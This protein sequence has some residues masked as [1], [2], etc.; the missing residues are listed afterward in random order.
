MSAPIRCETRDDLSMYAPKRARDAA[1][2][3]EAVLPNA[4]ALIE[5]G[6]RWLRPVAAFE[7][8]V[9]VRQ[10]R[11]RQ[12]IAPQRVPDPPLPASGNGAAGMFGRLFVAV[13]LA[14][15]AA[16]F[17][18]GAVP[19]PQVQSLAHGDPELAPA[20]LLSR[21]MAAGAS[22]NE[23]AQEMEQL[24]PPVAEPPA[25]AVVLAAPAAPPAPAV[26]ELDRD[27]IATLLKRGEEFVTQGD[28]AA[29]RLMLRRAAETR[30]PR[31]ALALGATYDPRALRALGV[32]GLAGDAG[33]ARAWY[34]KA[35]AYGSAEAARRLELSAQ[36]R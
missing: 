31:A 14:A 24:R 11:L 18:V 8:D 30:D 29:A 36:A 10:L 28:I 22:R 34:E 27:E 12:A 17:V 7:G 19:L 4:S 25:A 3:G 6:D 26:R 5:W 9:A 35:A 13:A 33:E 32:L 15:V 2:P 20:P 23:P 21:F 1:E 16:L